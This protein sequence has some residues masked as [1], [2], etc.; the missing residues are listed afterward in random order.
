MVQLSYI[1]WLCIGESF[2][3]FCENEGMSLL[4]Y[5][6][7]SSVWYSSPIEAGFPKGKFYGYCEATVYCG[8]LL[9]PRK[10]FRKVFEL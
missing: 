4:Y 8:T 1:G 2:F 5:G 9:L 10:V 6:E 3:D 7:V